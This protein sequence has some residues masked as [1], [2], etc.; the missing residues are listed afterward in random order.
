[1]KRETDKMLCGVMKTIF[2]KIFEKVFLQKFGK[3]GSKLR[4]ISGKS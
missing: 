1:M 3:K 4:M 2:L